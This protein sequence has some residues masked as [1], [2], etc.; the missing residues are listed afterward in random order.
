MFPEAATSGFPTIGTQ[1]DGC[2]VAAGNYRRRDTCCARNSEG[3]MHVSKWMT[4]NPFCVQPNDMLEAVADAMQRGRFRHAPVV[5]SDRRV[6][7]MVT[8][9]D[10]REQKGYWSSTRVSAALSEPAITVRA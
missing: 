5:A 3:P 9:R 6:I 8:E 10:L 1:S 7:G 2:G 4:H